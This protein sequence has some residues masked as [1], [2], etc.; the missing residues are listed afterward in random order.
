[1]ERRV[2]S[3]RR[4]TA[5]RLFFTVWLIFSV[6]ATTN[7]V[8]ETYLAI[9]LGTHGSVRVDEYLGLHPDLFEI[10]GRG[11]YINNNPGASMLGGVAYVFVRPAIAL[12][13]RIKP[14]IAAPKPPAIYDD[15]RPNRTRFMNAARAKGLDV[16]LGLA[17]IGIQVLLMAPLGALATLLVWRTLRG[18]VGSE[19]EALVWALVYAFATPMLFRSAFLN[20]NV[21]IAHLVL[22]SW[23]IMTRDTGLAD[24]RGFEATARP[25]S[26]AWHAPRD[27]FLIGLCL[28]SSLV[29]DY[30][31]VPFLVVFGLWILAEGW[32]W[33]RATGAL[34]FGVTYV[35]GALGPIALLLAYQWIA[36]GSPWYPA[37]RYMPPTEFSV[38]GWFGFTLPT[39]ELIWGNLFD[40]RYGIFAFCPLLLAG[41]A[42][43]WIRPAA[44]TPRPS[45]LRWAYACFA[46]L[47]LFSCANQF[48]NLQWNTGVRYMVPAVPLLFLAAVPVLRRMPALARWGLIG[49]SLVVSLAVSMTREDIPTALTLVLHTG[50]TLPVLIVADKMASGYSLQFPWWTIW[51]LYL[52]LAGVLWLTWRG[53][54]RKGI[55]DG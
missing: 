21:I 42:T 14:D 19:R 5:A 46:A 50:P 51:A 35:L 53:W 2:S 1:M 47:Y 25:M 41:L 31:A 48:A 23:L 49:L 4:G 30:S 6:H 33:G 16:T 39:Q 45:H 13:V 20:Q 28:G 11:G 17:A 37:Q 10:P 40:L 43:P 55:A 38:R 9:A 8:R 3:S 36:F 54:D 27:L 15:P 32:R 44:D 7:V 34:R 22:I 18:R 12:A 52:V 26:S 29:N 24:A